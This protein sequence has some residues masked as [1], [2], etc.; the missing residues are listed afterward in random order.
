MTEK[1]YKY[2]FMHLIYVGFIFLK[3]E[4]LIYSGVFII[5]ETINIYLRE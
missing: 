1:L 4:K 2:V 5:R 3:L